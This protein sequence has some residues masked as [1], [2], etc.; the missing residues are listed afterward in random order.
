MVAL[1]V[2]IALGVP[3]LIVAHTVM[4]ALAVRIAPCEPSLIVARL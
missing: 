3:S 1:A 2:I 4:V